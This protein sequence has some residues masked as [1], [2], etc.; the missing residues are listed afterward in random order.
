MGSK[1]SRIKVQFRQYAIDSNF[2]IFAFM[3]GNWPTDGIHTYHEKG[4]VQY[5][6]FHNCIEIGY[7]YRGC[8]RLYL[9][10][11]CHS[12]SSGD[13]VMVLPYTTH[14]TRSFQ[15]ETDSPAYSEYLYFDPSQLLHTFYPNGIP[16]FKVFERSSS[17]VPSIIR[18]NEYPSISKIMQEILKE[19]RSKPENYK[20]CVKGL[21][22]A[23]LMQLSRMIPEPAEHKAKEGRSI[24]T[25]FPAI[26][27]INDSF[28][29]HIA[30]DSLPE[31]CFLSATHFRRT[32]RTIMGCSPLEYIH[33]LRINRA[34]ELLYTSNESILNISL[35]VGFDSV[36]SFN[37]QFIQII[38]VAPSRWRQ[39]KLSKRDEYTAI[40]LYDAGRP[41]LQ[42]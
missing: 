23:L 41:Q 17:G 27:Y 31:M 8:G 32:F 24:L 26:Q 15:C 12:F 16:N 36:S 19:L 20:D 7:C 1:A 40:P 25:I 22:L 18:G 6:H 33:Q 10:D 35:A 29:E 2:P 21:V 5:M 28:A 3:E 34:C 14:I 42:K 37:R 13:T 39:E 38:G 30:I 9:E 4:P 11:A